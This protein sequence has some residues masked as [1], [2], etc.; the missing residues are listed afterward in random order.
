M[1][2]TKE[3]R[4][5]HVDE[6]LL[7]HFFNLYCMALSDSDFD[8][9]ESEV[10]YQIGLQ[11]G[12]DKSVINDIIVTSGLRPVQPHTLEEKVR[13]LYDLSKMAW[14]DGI[15]EG[16]ERDLLQK[17]VIR[18]GFEESNANAIVDYM[19]GSVKEGKSIEQVLTEIKV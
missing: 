19:L 7:W 9:R 3:E 5:E 2:T 18:F 8:P 14:A 1:E 11:Y 6:G 12:I 13:Y 17:T 10:L 16:S 4:K 15:I